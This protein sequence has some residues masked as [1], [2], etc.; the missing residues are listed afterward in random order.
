VKN[1]KIISEFVYKHQNSTGYFWEI[2]INFL[3]DNGK[4]IDVITDHELENKIAKKFILKRIINKLVISFRLVYKGCL[5]IK[6]GDIVLSGTNPELLLLFLS[7]LKKFIPFRWVV[8]VHDVF[9]ENL[10]PAGI[11][12][13]NAAS[14]KLIKYLFDWVFRQADKFIVI[15]RDMKT[16]VD[17]KTNQPAK[18]IYVRNWV[19]SEDVVVCDRN[20]S[21]LILRLN[22]QE[23]IVF[24]YFGNIGR[25]QDIDVLLKAVELVKSNKAAFIFIGDGAAASKVKDFEISGKNKFFFYLAGVNQNEKSKYLSACDVSLVSLKR[26]MFGL[27][28]PS[29]AYFS[30][31]AD[32]PILA[33]V[34]KGS[35]LEL[36]IKEYDVGWVSPPGDPLILAS[37]IDEICEIDLS[38]YKDR[39]RHLSIE[40]MTAEKSLKSLL[41]ALDEWD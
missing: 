12:T 36:M 20:E 33:V 7:I 9:P 41:A 11:M 17:G 24:Q 34:D 25:L 21:D 23:K 15:G 40:F 4:K 19:N 14:Y 5:K 1:I 38:K 8:V 6:P 32:R 18:S 10:V 28:V 29:K 2:A 26:G 30:L 22:L 31:A 39:M 13:R 37:K 16:L 27:G 35:E 3:I